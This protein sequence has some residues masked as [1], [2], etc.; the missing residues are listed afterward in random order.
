MATQ[1]PDGLIMPYFLPRE[2]I[3]DAFLSLN[4]NS[5]DDLPQNAIIGTSSLRRRA[6]LRR[7]RPDLT[8]IEFRGNLGTRLKKLEEGLADATLL[9]AAGLKRLGQSNRIIAYLDPNHFPPAPAQ[10]AIGL[11]LRAS[12]TRTMEIASPLNHA[13]T[14]AEITAERAMLKII[15]GSCRTPIGAVSHQK[16]GTLS[17]K[18]Q[19]L[20]PDGSQVFEAEISGPVANAK[21]LGKALGQALLSKAGSAFFTAL[22]T[23]K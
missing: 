11:E 17:L 6:Q 19:L 1:L 18:G 8:M 21:E 13:P 2:D 10:G 3:R 14:H 12:D 15:D 16:N 5:V 22:E 20:S 23:V 4:A 7:Y 9:A